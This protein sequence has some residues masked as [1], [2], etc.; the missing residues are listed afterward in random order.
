MKRR[1]INI[2]IPSLLLVICSAC[3]KEQ[4]TEEKAYAPPI[5][6]MAESPS[7]DIFNTTETVLPEETE[8]NNADLPIVTEADAVDEKEGIYEPVEPVTEAEPTAY[9]PEALPEATPT[10]F[11]THDTMPAKIKNDLA[12]AVIT[13]ASKGEKN[14]VDTLMAQIFDVDPY[15]ADRLQCVLDYWEQVNKD[16]FIYLFPDVDRIRDDVI[17]NGMDTTAFWG[18]EMFSTPLPSDDSLCFVIAGFEL[19]DNGTPKTEMIDRLVLAIGCAQKYPNA[20][21]LLTGG[22]TAV[23]NPNATEADVMADWLKEHGVAENR[24][25]VENK[26]TMTFEN[27]TFSYPIIKRDHPQIKKLAIVSSDYHIPMCAV[28]FQAE[29]ILNEEETFGMEVCAN[30][31]CITSGYN[32]PIDE[33][34]RQLIHILESMP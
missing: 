17:R 1:F 3:G 5:E 7:Q 11:Q 2:L 13:A 20:Y 4:K 31:G 27:A 14:K 23:G 34:K 21:I 32:F 15:W 19:N 22:P 9:E 30:V 10:P 29:C 18:R 8:I 25:I 16:Y 6:L 26:S 12:P 24:L 33:H 28:L